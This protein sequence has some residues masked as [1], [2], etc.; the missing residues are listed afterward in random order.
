MKKL[1]IALTALTSCTA[2]EMAKNYGGTETIELPEHNIFVNATW[3][4]DHL[5]F[6][7]KDT[8]DGKFYLREKSSYGVWEGQIIF[9]YKENEKVLR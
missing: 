3:K 4:D 5:W 7:T 2:N 1:L 8:T 9:K 6:L